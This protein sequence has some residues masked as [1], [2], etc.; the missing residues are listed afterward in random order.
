MWGSNIEDFLV[1]LVTSFLHPVPIFLKI[2]EKI[3][4]C[5]SPRRRPHRGRNIRKKCLNVNYDQKE[6]EALA[7]ELLWDC[8]SS[9]IAGANYVDRRMLTAERSSSRLKSACVY[10][11]LFNFFPSCGLILL[12]VAAFAQSTFTKIITGLCFQSFKESVYPSVP[13]FHSFVPFIPFSILYNEGLYSCIVL[14]NLLKYFSYLVMRK[15]CVYSNSICSLD[16]NWVV[17]F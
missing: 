12:L 15:E 11:K 2:W 4:R 6:R 7:V 9:K 10:I 17:W 3:K 14:W 16:K 8:R 13:I 1:F 5:S